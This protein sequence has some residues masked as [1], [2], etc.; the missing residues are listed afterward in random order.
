MRLLGRWSSRIEEFVH[1]EANIFDDLTEESGRDVA[2]LMHR[3]CGHSAVDVTELFVRTALPRFLKSQPLK[4][5]DNL[6]SLED[7]GLR[8]CS[9]HDSLDADEFGL[10]LWFTIL[11]EEK[12]DFLEV[13]IELVQCLP[14]A[15]R[16]RE[17]GH[18][19]DVQLGIGVT[20]ND[21]GEG[22]HVR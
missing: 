2:T 7:W 18:V 22:L 3:H 5:C 21:R 4:P 6:A 19:A 8:H 17:T 12:N 11:E 16:T 20:L 14:L 10:K 13:A 15:V 1:R 9:R